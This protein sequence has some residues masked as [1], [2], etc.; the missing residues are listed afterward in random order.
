[1]LKWNAIL[2]QSRGLAYACIHDFKL[3]LFS[4]YYIMNTEEKQN[5]SILLCW[6]SDYIYMR[7]ILLTTSDGERC[8]YWGLRDFAG[9]RRWSFKY[10]H[11]GLFLIACM[12]D[13]IN[14]YIRQERCCCMPIDGYSRRHCCYMLS[15]KYYIMRR[16]RKLTLLLL[17]MMK[18]PLHFAPASQHYNLMIF[19]VAGAMPYTIIMSL[20]RYYFIS[21]FIGHGYGTWYQ[22]PAA[23]VYIL[24][25]FTVARVAAGLPS[26]HAVISKYALAFFDADDLMIQRL[27][28]YKS[29]RYQS[30]L[31]F[32]SGQFDTLA[33]SIFRQDFDFHSGPRALPHQLLSGHFCYICY[34]SLLCRHLSSL[35]ERIPEMRWATCVYLTTTNT[36]SASS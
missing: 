32:T 9:F 26:P 14:K 10:E 7:N 11:S 5:G 35:S 31:S 1:M 24:I 8:A 23:Y 22:P 20:H 36:S 16:R 19:K 21:A 27:C 13:T 12:V 15:F 25:S 4:F 30:I 29:F 3:L 33:E 6:F 18:K 17:A 2:K 34:I 28:Y